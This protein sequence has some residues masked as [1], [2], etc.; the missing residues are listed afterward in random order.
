[1]PLKSLCPVSVSVHADSVI[2]RKIDVADFY[3]PFTL[4]LKARGNSSPHQGI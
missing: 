2:D 3:I 4:K 1:M